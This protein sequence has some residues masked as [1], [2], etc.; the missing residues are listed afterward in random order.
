MFKIKIF[1]GFSLIEIMIVIAIIGI[2]AAIAIPNYQ[3]Y[4]IRSQVSEI[5]NLARPLQKVIEEALGAGTAFPD[6]SKTFQTGK[7]VTGIYYAGT[8]S[9]G[10]WGF[11]FSTNFPNIIGTFI[12]VW[13]ATLNP[14]TGIISWR[15]GLSGP[16]I[17]AGN[18]KYVPSGSGCTGF[19]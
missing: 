15:C 6:L 11:A 17:S 10:G 4:V 16:T 12:P 1:K 14:T 8:M 3:T 7:Y 2:L 9:D 5:Y 13:S 19:L 18:Q